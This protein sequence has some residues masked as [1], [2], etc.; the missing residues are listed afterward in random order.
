MKKKLHDVH[1]SGDGVFNAASG[2]LINLHNPTV[3]MICIEDIASALSKVCRFG[4]HSND[5]YSVAQHSVVVASLAPEYLCREALLHD[6]A[7]AYLGDVIKP[8]KNIIGAAYEDIEHKF[9]VAICKK[10]NLSA[11]NLWEVKKYDKEALTIEHAYFIK[12][13]MLEWISAMHRINLNSS[14]WHHKEAKSKFLA[15]YKL[16]F[17]L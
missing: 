14:T 3:D 10:F 11:D 13:D 7:E 15:F 5:F 1:A 4:G 12:G 6:A 17:E 9:M 16:F 2:V 8:L